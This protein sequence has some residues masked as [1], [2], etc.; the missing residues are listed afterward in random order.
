[1]LAE[2]STETSSSCAAGASRSPRLGLVRCGRAGAVAALAGHGVDERAVV[3]AQLDRA[4]LVEV[5]GQGRLGDVDAVGGEQVGELALRADRRCGRAA[6]TMRWCRAALVWRTVM[7]P[8]RSED[9][10]GSA[11]TKESASA[12]VRTSGGASRSASGGTALTRKPALARAPPRPRPTGLGQHDARSRP[13]RAP[14]EQRVVERLDAVGEPGADLGDVREQAVGLDRVEHGERRGAGDRVAAERRAV[15]ARART[16]GRAAPKPTQAPMRQPAAEALGERDDVG[17][18]AVAP[19]ANHSPVRPMPV[20][21]SSRTSSAPVA[22]QISRRPRGSPGGADDAALAL[23]RL[24]HDRGASRRRPPQRRDVAVRH[25][26]HVGGAAA[27]TAPLRGLAGQRERADRAAVE[28]A[29]G[30]DDSAAGGRR[31]GGPS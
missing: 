27:R 11:A 4:E 8:P 9:R 1:M 3:G 16:A 25:E 31:G 20:C 10:P 13:R 7:T 2:V 21:T 22:S 24:E 6:S 12:A 18:D 23:H 15:L 26:A 17:Q 14:R 5:A 29:L 28:G 19:V 30:G